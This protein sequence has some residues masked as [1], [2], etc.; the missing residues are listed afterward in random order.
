MPAGSLP[1]SH[2]VKPKQPIASP[3]AMRGSHV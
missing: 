1:K 3:R 2:S